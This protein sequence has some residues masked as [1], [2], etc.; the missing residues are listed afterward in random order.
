MIT[1][2]LFIEMFG[3]M[4]SELDK[5]FTQY[6]ANMKVATVKVAQATATAV[7]QDPR[8]S[9]IEVTALEYEA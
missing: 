2:R 7:E 6:N 8:G 4:I 1:K 3:Q 9:P 5:E